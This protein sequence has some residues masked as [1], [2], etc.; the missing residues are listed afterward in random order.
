MFSLKLIY[1]VRYT[2]IGSRSLFSHHLI[3]GV[4]RLVRVR[5]DAL[6][7]GNLFFLLYDQY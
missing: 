7:L 5:L 2:H 4:F 6:F 1:S 3:L